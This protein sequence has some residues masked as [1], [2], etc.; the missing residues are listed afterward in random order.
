M[1]RDDFKARNFYQDEGMPDFETGLTT[2][3]ELVAEINRGFGQSAW[4]YVA[5]CA[6][7]LVVQLDRGVS[8]SHSRAREFAH[9][10]HRFAICKI[11]GVL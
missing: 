3:D 4:E 7:E 10:A 1:Y 5:D 6:R 9:D 11:G 2:P 8:C